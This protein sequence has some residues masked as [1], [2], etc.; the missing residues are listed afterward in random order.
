MLCSLRLPPHRPHA[1]RRS[2]LYYCPFTGDRVVLPVSGFG[3]PIL[4]LPSKQLRVHPDG[5][6][7][8]IPLYTGWTLGPL[9]R[10]IAAWAVAAKRSPAEGA[11]DA[12]G[13]PVST[14]TTASSSVARGT[15]QRSKTV[16]ETSA[17]QARGRGGGRGGD[18][19]GGHP[20]P[21]TMVGGGGGGNGGGG[22]GDAVLASIVAGTAGARLPLIPGPDETF[23]SR[24]TGVTG[25]E[26]QRR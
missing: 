26:A 11:L 21:A 17:L 7:G 5:G 9:P 13:L 6:T 25:E 3:H 20:D 2:Y 18:V 24:D 14:A 23:V 1:R 19:H 4:P 8:P 10:H 15:R 22:G 16:D 12:Y